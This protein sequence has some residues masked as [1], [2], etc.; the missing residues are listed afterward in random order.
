MRPKKVWYN[1][2][3]MF[4]PELKT[5]ISVIRKTNQL[6]RRRFLRTGSN[7]IHFKKH[8]EIVTCTDLEANRLI[9]KT[10][11][12]KFPSYDIVS[13]EAKTIDN[14]G[15]K[16]WYL[17]PLDGTTNFAY[18]FTE[19]STCLGLEDKGEIKVGAIGL[20]IMKEIYWA[21]KNNGA[22]CNRRRLRLTAK[23][24]HDKPM[25]LLCAGHSPPG[26]DRFRKFFSRLDLIQ[27]RFRMLFSA[28]VE[29]AA[30]ASGRADACL[31]SE[32]N[33]WDVLAGVV[34]VREAGGKVINWQGK[35]WQLNDKT[36]IAGNEETMAQMLKLTKNVK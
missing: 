18:G 6:L 22:W 1:Q 32:I 11:L 8:A 3:N 28:G 13:E 4:S 24:K 29:L 10:L 36:L 34:I 27:V 19:F 23:K 12:E 17:D 9:T 14:P 7:G 33:P 30:V 20:P 2:H 31:L 25:L 5:A 16:T 35:E 15:S 21:E 26:R